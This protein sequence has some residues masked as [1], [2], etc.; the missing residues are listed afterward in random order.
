MAAAAKIYAQH[1]EPYRYGMPLWIPEPAKDLQVRIG[2][3]GV[4]D[5]Q[6]QF[7]RFFNVTVESDHPYNS[8][9]V[10]VDF[11]RLVF[12][13]DIISTSVV[14]DGI[15]PSSS[16]RYRKI[17]ARIAGYVI[18]RA[19]PFTHRLT[20]EFGTVMPQWLERAPTCPIL[21]GAHRNKERY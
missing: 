9:G 15:F 14:R 5:E 4:V 2:D 20:S 1:L 16:V 12:H 13:K 10:P 17:G 7:Q 19:R 6:G 8:R 21:L 11:E 3:V 18:T